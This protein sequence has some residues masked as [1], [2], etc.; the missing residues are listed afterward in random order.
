VGD[1]LFTV[2]VQ[3]IATS[4][5]LIAAAIVHAVLFV[6][7]VSYI[8]SDRGRSSIEARVIAEEARRDASTARGLRVRRQFTSD[9]DRN[10][11]YA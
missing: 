3:F 5:W 10:V 6:I 2:D 8:L 9:R 1:R 4:G 11:K 7:F